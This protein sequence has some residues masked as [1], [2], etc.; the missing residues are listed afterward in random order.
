MA[1]FQAWVVGSP[2]MPG[3]KRDMMAKRLVI[4]DPSAIATLVG[5]CQEEFQKR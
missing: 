1:P 2:N 4:A 3:T 5:F